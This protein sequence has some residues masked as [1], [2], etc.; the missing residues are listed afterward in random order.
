MLLF[1]AGAVLLVM[2]VASSFKLSS[3]TETQ[4]A[5]IAGERL[6]RIAARRTKLGLLN[7]ETGQRGFL[8]TG[9]EIYL[10]PYYRGIEE[11]KKYLA[12]LK[13]QAKEPRDIER[14]AVILPVVEKKIAEMAKTI[15]L[16]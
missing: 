4:A 11:T 12:E 5:E 7:A 3:D 2:L 10:E 6:V 13:A 9:E 16:A 15:S 1:A 14:V 8:L